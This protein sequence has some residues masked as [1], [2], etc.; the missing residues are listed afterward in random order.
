MPLFGESV[1][2]LAAGLNLVEGEEIG[3]DEDL[4][5]PAERGFEIVVFVDGV[6]AVAGR[7][8]H[9]AGRDVIISALGE[10]Y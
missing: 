9:A 4:R 1:A 2:L 7:G 8:E 5:E 3:L 10:I 6:L